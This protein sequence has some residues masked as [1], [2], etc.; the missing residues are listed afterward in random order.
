MEM[1]SELKEVPLALGQIASPEGRNRDGVWLFWPSPSV[2]CR[3]RGQ[4]C[5]PAVKGLRVGDSDT[6][7]AVL[8]KG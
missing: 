1:E 3:R 4:P 7:P 5:S 2:W 6:N 8:L